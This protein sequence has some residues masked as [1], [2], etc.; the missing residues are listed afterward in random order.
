MSKRRE[1]REAA[2]QFLYQQ[3]IHGDRAADLRTDFWNFREAKASVRE[4]A[5]NL[6]AG[7][8][9]NLAGVDAR[10]V[11]TVENFGIERLAAVDRNILRLAIYEM[12]HCMETPPVVAINE[13]IEIARK[14]GGEDSSRFVNGVLDKIKGELTRP[15]REAVVPRGDVKSKPQ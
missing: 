13:A 6:I 8:N 9:A 15:L 5:D 12:F 2:V 4:Y 10:I 11:K 7:V 14:F 3:D 1:G